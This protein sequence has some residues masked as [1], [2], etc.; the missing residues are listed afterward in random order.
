MDLKP[1]TTFEEQLRILKTRG[2][3]IDDYDLCLSFIKRVN[4]YKFSAYLLPFKCYDNDYISGT[5]FEKII[6]IYEFDRKCRLLILKIIEEIEIFLR[7][8]ISYYFVHKYGADGYLD[9]NNFNEEHNHDK[10]IESI[11]NEI[12]KQRKGKSLITTHHDTKYDKKYPLWVLVEFF[13]LGTLSKFYCDL[14]NDDKNY[15]AKELFNTKY[16][17]LKSWLICLTNLRNRCAHYSRIYNYTFNFV[18]K[19]IISDNNRS[20]F[21]QIIL[22]KK[23][24]PCQDKWINII[25]ELETIISE[26]S[27][28]INLEHLGFPENWYNELN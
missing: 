22:L 12:A 24:Y 19:G 10:F 21:C 15:L 27:E 28:F 5:T 20:L 9:K 7:T 18:P 13:S 14:K 11:E 16:I 8:R 25:T 26:Y 6:N 2:L 17:F 4:Y 3:I 1:A 23:L